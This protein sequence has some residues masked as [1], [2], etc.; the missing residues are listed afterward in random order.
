MDKLHYTLF[1]LIGLSLI[2]SGIAIASV[3]GAYDQRDVKMEL[4]VN[5][6][7]NDT[8][9]L[10]ENQSL[11]AEALGNMINRSANNTDRIIELEDYDI[12]ITTQIGNI[13]SDIIRKFPQAADVI[14]EGQSSTIPGTPFLTLVMEQKSF[15]LGNTVVFT[16]MAHPNTAIFLTIKDP[17][18][19]LWQIAIS[20]TEIIDGQYMADYTLRLDEPIGSWSVYA[21]QGSDTTKLLKFTVT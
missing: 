6:L 15:V 10:K 8:K 19:E 3:Q 1:L 4:T 2:I 11:F 20:K 21:R 5:A 14:D 12:T 16:G 9:H 17:N 7:L 13:R 18:R